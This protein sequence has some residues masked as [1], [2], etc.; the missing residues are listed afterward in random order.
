[1]QRIILGGGCFWCTQSVFSRVRGVSAVTAGYAGGS[2]HTADYQSV[3]TGETGHVEVIDVAFD[4]GV[5]SLDVL[6]DIFF[7]THDPTTPNRQGNDIGTQYASVIF[8]TDEA[9]LAII[10]QKLAEL[11]KLGINAVTR[12]EPAPKFYAA[13][14]YHQDFFAKNPEQGYCNFAIP[15][16]L[17][18]LRTVFGEWVKDGA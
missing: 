15:P 2:A 16:K 4:D 3:C 9:Q 1:M 8:Y 14:D 5:V 6:L 18:K 11:G 13:E 10:K 12:I 17:A 7:A